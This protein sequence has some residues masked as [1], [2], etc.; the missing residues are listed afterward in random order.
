MQYPSSLRSLLG[1]F[2]FGVNIDGCAKMNL[3]RMLDALFHPCGERAVA[4][5]PDVF[6]V[7]TS[8]PNERAF[9]YAAYNLVRFARR[10]PFFD[11]MQRVLGGGAGTFVDVGANLGLYSYLAGTLGA[12]TIL[13][14][15]EPA[16]HAF[17]KRNAHLFGDVRPC[18]LSDATGTMTFYVGDLQHAGASSLVLPEGGWEKSPYQSAIEVPVTTFDHALRVSATDPADVVLIKIDVEGNERRT[19][20]GMSGYLSRADA[21]PVWCEVRGPASDRGCNSFADVIGQVARWGYKPYLFESSEIR[22]FSA[23]AS[24]GLP[25]VFDLLLLVPERHAAL[26]GLL[27]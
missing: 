13:F 12:R 25:Q 18:A 14:E 27:P 26:I 15:P 16:H 2:P 19:V 9:Y 1:T 10:S 22:P 7:D 6:T 23:G 3:L 11:V 17:L 20:Q 8:N 21:A 24:E 5:G 4:L